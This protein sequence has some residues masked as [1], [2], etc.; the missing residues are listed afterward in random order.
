MLFG[1]I[2]LSLGM[3]ALIDWGGDASSDAEDSPEAESFPDTDTTFIEGT[4]G[5]DGYPDIPYGTEGPDVFDLGSGNDTAF[6]NGGDDLL[7][8]GGGN[9]FANG[10]FGDDIMDGGNGADKLLGAPGDDDLF[11]SAGADVLLGQADDDDLFGGAGDDELFGGAGF[12][13]LQG[14]ADDDVLNGGEGTDTLQGGTGDD[15]I[16]GALAL[17]GEEEFGDAFTAAVA[18]GTV[19]LDLSADILQGGPGEDLMVF[20]PGDEVS[21]GVDEDFYL[22]YVTDPWPGHATITDMEAGAQLTLDVTRVAETPD[23]DALAFAAQGNGTM[24]SYNGVD[25]VL[26]QN[27]AADQ[28]SVT[29]IADGVG[30]SV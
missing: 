6:G 18:A 28:F 20:G 23:A 5:D 14:G 30:V 17:D 22:G 26:L 2:F 25:I 11:G 7:Q 13:L 1:L 24:V 16:D 9:D 15:V 21:G 8:M 10:G 12:D 4:S 19:P 29:L 3:V 27:I